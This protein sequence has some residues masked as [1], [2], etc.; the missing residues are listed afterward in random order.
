MDG[1]PIGI[2]FTLLGTTALLFNGR[3]TGLLV[4]LYGRHAERYPLLYP[5][6]LRRLVQ[7]PSFVRWVALSFA[8]SLIAF[9][10]VAI[11][12]GV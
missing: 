9:G 6:F 8:V 12:V 7:D 1:V 10:V 2:I 4:R 5:S 3:L 11:K